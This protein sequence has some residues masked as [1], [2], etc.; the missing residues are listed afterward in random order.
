MSERRLTTIRWLSFA[1]LAL[2]GWAADAPAQESAPDID[3]AQIRFITPTA[4]SSS[5]IG[6]P[7]TPL[8]ALDTLFACIAR[9]ELRLC[10][11]V[12]IFDYTPPKPAAAYRYRVLWI[13]I[14]TEA[15]MRPDLAATNWWKPGYAD[16]AVEHLDLDYHNVGQHNTSYSLRPTVHGW[17]VITWAVW[18]AENVDDVK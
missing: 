6:D 14:L 15:D 10:H 7:R 1:L 16:I 5:C 12:R 9:N 13:K 3:P 4:S 11:R 18:G 2:L 8:C 17:E